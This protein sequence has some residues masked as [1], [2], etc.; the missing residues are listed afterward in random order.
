MTAIFFYQ[1]KIQRVRLF[2][3][4]TS[5]TPTIMNT[6]P[7][8]VT[9]VTPTTA[10]V[11]TVTPTTTTV[12]TTTSISTTQNPYACGN[13]TT[14]ISSDLSG[15]NIDI[16]SGT[17][18]YTSCCGWCQSYIGCVA[19]TWRTSDGACF[20]KNATVSPTTSSGL[21]SAHY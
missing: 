5:M 21:I 6:I 12:T 18:N 2:L 13:M 16:A 7:T 10:T 9:T 20:L 15:P 19:Y 3:G 17:K 11:T 4:Q 8:T 14:L 1:T